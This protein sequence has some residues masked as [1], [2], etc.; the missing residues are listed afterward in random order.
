MSGQIAEYISQDS[1]SK[2]TLL[3]DEIDGFT[4]DSSKN[5]CILNNGHPIRYTATSIE[6]PT[7][8]G[9]L[10][11]QGDQVMYNTKG[12]KLYIQGS[13]FNLAISEV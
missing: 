12:G 8:F 2:W 13:S 5:Y 6:N 4:F 10:F 11:N 1:L 7:F 9:K 3:E